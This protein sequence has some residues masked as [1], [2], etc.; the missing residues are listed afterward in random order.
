MA[1][2]SSKKSAEKSNTGSVSNL[3]GNQQ[4]RW[5]R[6]G[7]VHPGLTNGDFINQNSYL[8]RYEIFDDMT[9]LVSL[10]P[11]DGFIFQTNFQ[12]HQSLFL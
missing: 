4:P 9:R 3:T 5:S 11:K 7:S 6:K 8:T 10:F 2:E 12:K 1:S